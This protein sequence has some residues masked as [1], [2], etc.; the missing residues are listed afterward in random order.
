MVGLLAPAGAGARFSE[1]VGGDRPG[2][3]SA[4]AA[5]VVRGARGG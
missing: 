2:E 3:L 5:F 1:R 4:R